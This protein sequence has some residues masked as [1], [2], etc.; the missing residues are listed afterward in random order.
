M[1][2]P[3]QTCFSIY[4]FYFYD[5]EALHWILNNG[6]GKSMYG[7]I[8][9]KNLHNICIFAFSQTGLMAS[10][11]NTYPLIRQKGSFHSNSV[12]KNFT[13]INFHGKMA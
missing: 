8:L 2:S 3:Y 9:L 11:I 1:N 5:R 4:T 13:V 7:R 10:P 12:E 6:S